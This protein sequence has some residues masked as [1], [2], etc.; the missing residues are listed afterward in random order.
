MHGFII[1]G[2]ELFLRTRHGDEVWAKVSS[3]AGSTGAAR[4]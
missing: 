4:C 3:A 1:R 2:I